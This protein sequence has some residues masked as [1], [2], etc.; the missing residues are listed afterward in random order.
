M[1]P[2][3]SMDEFKKFF[4]DQDQN[5]SV[6]NFFEFSTDD[7]KKSKFDG[8]TAYSRVSSRKLLEK[9]EVIEG[10]AKSIVKDFLE[11]GGSIVDTNLSNLCIETDLG[12]FE[13]PRFCVDII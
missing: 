5:K 12:K 8:C 13:I 9:I 10:D 3:F 2:K 6:E 4:A 11:N 1:A 7:S